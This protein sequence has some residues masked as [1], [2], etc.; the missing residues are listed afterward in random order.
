M[1]CYVCTEPVTAIE[2]MASCRTVTKDPDMVAMMGLTFC[3]GP[4][5]LFH[6]CLCEGEGPDYT[7]PAVYDATP[8]H[9]ESKGFQGVANTC[10]TCT[11]LVLQ[12]L[13]RGRGRKP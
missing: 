2:V 6:N 7:L 4:N 5:D 13:E 9:D 3:D 12:F 10:S 1:R 8:F 11:G